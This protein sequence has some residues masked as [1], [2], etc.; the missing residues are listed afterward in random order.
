MLEETEELCNWP[1]T[2][3]KI[4]F[5]IL[6]TLLALQFNLVF[7]FSLFVFLLLILIQFFSFKIKLKIKI[8]YE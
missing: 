4:R 1:V 2:S 7:Y 5:F 3:S 6:F 8:K